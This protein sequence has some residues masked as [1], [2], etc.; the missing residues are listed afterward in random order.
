MYYREHQLGDLSVRAL[1]LLGLVL[2]PHGVELPDDQAVEDQDEGQ[3][4]GE[5]Q[6]Q[7]V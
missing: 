5:A 1:L 3:W 6:D 4:S 7:G 2:G